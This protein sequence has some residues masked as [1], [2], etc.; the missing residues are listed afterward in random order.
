MQIKSAL[1]IFARE[2][3]DGKVKTRLARDLPVRVVT[4]LYKAFIRDVIQVVRR[5]PCEA[6][7]I[8]YDAE[9]GTSIPFL[10]KAATGF[11]FKRQT[12]RDLGERMHKA[13]EHCHKNGF[14]RIAILGSDCVT[15]TAKD[16]E[17]AFR[18][19]GSHDCVLGPAK[20]GGY[21][22]IAMSQPCRGVFQGVLWGTSPV[23]EQTLGKARALGKTV[24]LLGQRGDI[25]EIDDLRGFSRRAKGS[26]GAMHTQKILARLTV[27]ARSS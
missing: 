9:G 21:Y 16:M 19:L 18:A 5:V 25:D 13:F 27:P 6:R 1:I 4:C 15:V 24:F 17:T 26:S 10:R 3:K 20:D 11:R 22:L 12:G 23:L 7:F 2:P 8:F 14:R